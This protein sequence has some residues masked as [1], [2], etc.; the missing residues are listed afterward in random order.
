M[1]RGEWLRV[2]REGLGLPLDQVAAK[3]CLA[4]SRLLAIEDGNDPVSLAEIAA[5]SRTLGF[6]SDLLFEDALAPPDPK[7]TVRVLL[8]SELGVAL[9]PHVK[10]LVIDA[11]QAAHDTLR[12]SKAKPTRTFAEHPVKADIVAQ[13]RDLARMVRRD[14]GIVDRAPIASMHR[15]VRDALGIPV[16]GEDLSANGPDALTVI[17]PGRRAAILINLAGKNTNH[18]ARRFSLAHELCHALFDWAGRGAFSCSVARDD[19][20]HTQTERRANAFAMRL[21]LP[22]EVI[23]NIDVASFSSAESRALIETYGVHLQALR[24]YLKNVRSIIVPA[25]VDPTPPLLVREAEELE[26]ERAPR[27]WWAGIPA[28]RRGELARLVTQAWM[29]EEVA[30]DELR[31]LLRVPRSFDVAQLRDYFGLEKSSTRE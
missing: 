11:A 3:A 13:G 15:L 24:L 4:E 6:D 20:H 10:L 21:I 22:E 12:F 8:K 25:G 26:C 1:T 30:E 14:L 7:A 31:E 9:S 27:A 5:L 2:Y 17:E 19:G 23:Q 16:L 28:G 29:D 18:L